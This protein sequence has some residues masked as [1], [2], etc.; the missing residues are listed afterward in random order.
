MDLPESS[1]KWGADFLNFSRNDG[2]IFYDPSPQTEDGFSS[3]PL[4]MAVCLS[5]FLPKWG[6][7][8]YDSSPKRGADLP[9]FFLKIGSGL[10]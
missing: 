9:Y 3:V 7:D 10:D 5:K 2:H 8:F 6:I 4:R 1:P